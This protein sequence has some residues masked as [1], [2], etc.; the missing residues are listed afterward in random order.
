[1]TKIEWMNVGKSHFAFAHGRQVAV[2]RCQDSNQWLCALDGTDDFPL[3][4]TASEQDA[5]QKVE[6]LLATQLH[7]ALQGLVDE[8]ELY[9]EAE[10]LR[11]AMKDLEA[12]GKLCNE[13]IVVLRRSNGSS[14]A[15]DFPEWAV[16]EIEYGRDDELT[17][18]EH[19]MV[20]D[21]RESFAIPS[22]FEFLDDRH[23]SRSPEFGMPC[24]CVTCIITKV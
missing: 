13:Q 14:I 15:E 21:W 8:P 17:K 24:T 19:I 11:E 10:N 4:C 3:K 6:K 5:K 9:E 20:A 16:Q 12:E 18:E 23:F 2:L 22:D 7:A 1:M